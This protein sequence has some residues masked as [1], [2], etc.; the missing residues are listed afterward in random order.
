MGKAHATLGQSIYGWCVRAWQRLWITG[1]RFVG[2]VIT[3]DEKDIGSFC[4]AQSSQQNE[5]GKEKA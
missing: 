3:Q 4:S 1:N 5:T 2:L